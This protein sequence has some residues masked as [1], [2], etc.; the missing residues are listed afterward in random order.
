[1]FVSSPKESRKTIF[2]NVWKPGEEISS[3]SYHHLDNGSDFLTFVMRIN[4][5]RGNGFNYL[6]A[7]MEADVSRL[8]YSE[9]L[10]HGHVCSET[11]LALNPLFLNSC[12][13]CGASA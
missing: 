13:L 7:L 11:N 2:A 1:M 10:G 8:V 5:E 4:S 12:H 9:P 3:Y 6:L